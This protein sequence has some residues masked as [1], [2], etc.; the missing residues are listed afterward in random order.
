MLELFKKYNKIENRLANCIRFLTIDAVNNAKSGHLGMPMGMADI[1]TVLF[2]DFFVF[3]PHDP[4]WL[5]R[6][7]LIISNGHGS[8]LLYSLLYLTGYEDVSINDIKNFRQLNSNAKGHPEYGTF[9]G[10]ETTTGPLGQG[11]GNAVGMALAAKISKS[12]IHSD[13]NHKIYCT[14]GD[15]CLMEG[16]SQEVITFASHYELDNLILIFD[17]NEITIDGKTNTSTSENQVERFKASGWTV[18]EIDGHDIDQIKLTFSTITA[19]KIK[20]PILINAKTIIGFGDCKNQRTN[21]IHGSEIDMDSI[22]D[23]KKLI[24]WKD[25]EFEMPPKLLSQWRKFWTRNED[26]YNNTK[27]LYNNSID[28]DLIEKISLKV[29]ELKK[30]YIKEDVH[31]STRKALNMMLSGLDDEQLFLYGSADLGNSTMI[32]TEKSNDISGK[33]YRGNYI[34]FGVREHAMA[35]ISNGISLYGNHIPVISTFLAFSDYMRPAIRMSAMMKQKIIYILT[36]DSIGVGEDGPTHQPIEQISSLRLIPNLQVFRPCDIVELME[37]YSIA[38]N[39]NLASVIILSRQNIDFPRNLVKDRLYIDSNHA[40]KGAYVIFGFY[41]EPKISIIA[42]GSEV[43]I[44]LKI[45]NKLTN[46]HRMS[47]NVVSMPCISIFDKQSILYKSS[48]ITKNSFKVAIEFGCGNMFYKYIGE[49]GL[50]IGIESFGESAKYEDLLNYFEL[51][52][53]SIMN[54]ILDKFNL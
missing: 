38:I 27:N 21:A 9:A 45:A 52:E 32:K 11:V 22:N 17:D 44:A 25:S 51:D 10:I 36:H 39:I 20:K 24:D 48:T 1:M 34:N 33:S 26:L 35:A 37:C 43:S 2:K 54:K 29:N 23:F 6:D 53:E 3:N 31:I 7:R 49:N 47:V 28:K 42:T 19:N 50:F 46:E 18:I 12:V 40:S 16:L 8:M 13:I 15:G 30:Y 5:N 14:V 41:D 4:S